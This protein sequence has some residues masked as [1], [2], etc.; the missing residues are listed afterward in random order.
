[1]KLAIHTTIELGS[2]AREKE[3]ERGNERERETKDR[4]QKNRWECDGNK[5]IA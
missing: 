1:L 5:G 4:R 2:L 3:K